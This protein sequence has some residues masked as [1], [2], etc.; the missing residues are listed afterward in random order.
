MVGSCLQQK[1][2][3]S[4][5][6]GEPPEGFKFPLEDYWIVARQLLIFSS[7]DLSSAPKNQRLKVMGQKVKQLSPFGKTG[8]YVHWSDGFAQVWIWDEEQRL[9]SVEELCERFMPLANHFRQ[10]PP[11]PETILQDVVQEGERK[12]PCVD[13]TDL[14]VWHQG[15]LISSSW[16]PEVQSGLLN[17]SANV[18]GWATHRSE[19]DETLAWQGGLCVLALVVVFQLGNSFGLSLKT[20]NLEHRISDAEGE[21]SAVLEVRAKVRQIKS[22]TDTLGSWFDQPS[23]LSLFAEFDRLMPESVEIVSWAYEDKELEVLLRD[24]ALD[25]RLYIEQ[26]SGVP[27]FHGS[28]VEPGTSPDTATVIFSVTTR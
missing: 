18:D 9:E 17:H 23:Q 10:L 7:F 13:G 6:Y 25:N 28:R 24:D 15:R 22:G 4:F 26:L 20:N 1:N 12:Q 11:I 8:H 14:Q 3:V 5:Q 16:S 21:M 27:R 2:F 19:F